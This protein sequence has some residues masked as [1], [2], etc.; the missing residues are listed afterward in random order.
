MIADFD[1]ERELHDGV[2]GQERRELAA[3]GLEGLPCLVL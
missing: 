2:F 1:A 3:A